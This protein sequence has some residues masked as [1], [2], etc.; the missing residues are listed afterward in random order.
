MSV[1]AAYTFTAFSLGGISVNLF[2][3]EGIYL[4]GA[5]RVMQ[6]QSLYRN[7]LGFVGPGTDWLYAA[8]LSTFGNS[9]GAAHG[10]LALEVGLIAASVYLIVATAQT[11][12]LY[13]LAA[14]VSFTALL[15]VF[16]HRVYVNHRWDSLGFAS[17]SV[18]TLFYKRT[19]ALAFTAGLM[20]AFAV[21][22][23]PSTALIA[24]VTAAYLI[25]LREHKNALLFVLGLAAPLVTVAAVLASQHALTPMLDSFRWASAHYSAANSVSYCYEPEST[26]AQT[27][28]TESLPRRLLIAIPSALP[29][30]AAVLFYLMKRRRVSVSLDLYWLLAVGVAA[31]LACY[32]RW[33][34]NQLLFAS[35]F[36][37]AALFLLSL[38][39]L[40]PK[41][42]R[43]VGIG[44]TALF[45]AILFVTVTTIRPAAPVRTQLGEVLCNPSDRPSIEFAIAAVQPGESL[46]VFP[47]QPIWYS[48]TGGVNPTY[49][50]FLQPGM[51]TAEDEARCLRELEARPPDWV[52]WHNLPA[53]TVL[54]IWPHSNPAT[55][56]FTRIEQFIRTHYRQVRPPDP[57][58]R[59]SIAVFGRPKPMP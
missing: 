7:W 14:S 26:S 18:A 13:S 20:S 23:T 35:P 4:H 27:G 48:L 12:W 25:L 57:H 33:A 40:P 6:G 5:E 44:L 51:M 16:P 37:I 10:F 32:P 3:D 56:R 34:A 22:A 2:L 9:L 15:T 8:V 43:P 1:A 50:D 29:F 49:Y 41:Q 59:Y 24:F 58:A 54:A 55:L 11:T 47:Y 42:V 30:V 46:F 28:Q 21:L 53:K 36:F 39:L 17:L 52:I 38:K 19:P 31:V 45:G